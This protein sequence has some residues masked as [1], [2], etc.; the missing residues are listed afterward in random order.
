MF[1][2]FAL[3]RQKNNLGMS[4]LT[5]RKTWEIGNSISI[6]EVLSQK[7]GSG[8]TG[9]T[10]CSPDLDQYGVHEDDQYLGQ[11]R[12]LEP[13]IN[14]T[15]HN[16]V[17]AKPGQPLSSLPDAAD[18]QNE[19]ISW[20]LNIHDGRAAGSN[21]AASLTSLP[22]TATGGG[23]KAYV[24]A[25]RIVSAEGGGRLM[26]PNHQQQVRRLPTEGHSS[27]S[28]WFIELPEREDQQPQKATGKTSSAVSARP[29]TSSLITASN[30]L[31]SQSSRPP[32]DHSRLQPR[33]LNSKCPVGQL[34]GQPSVSSTADGSQSRPAPVMVWPVVSEAQGPVV[35]VARGV[36]L[37]E[38]VIIR[39]SEKGGA[40][41]SLLVAT[42]N[43]SRATDGRIS[44]GPSTAAGRSR[45]NKSSRSTTVL[46]PPVGSSSRSNKFEGRAS[47]HAAVRVSFN[48]LYES[49]WATGSEEEAALEGRLATDY[50]P[51]CC[52]INYHSSASCSSQSMVVGMRNDG[53][54][55]HCC[56]F[57]TNKI[58]KSSSSS[59]LT[60]SGVVM[61]NAGDDSA[62]CR[63]AGD[64]SVECRSCSSSSIH[65]SSA[66][67]QALRQAPAHNYHQKQNDNNT[68]AAKESDDQSSLINNRCEQ[69]GLASAS[70]AGPH[71]PTAGRSSNQ[72]VAG[73]WK[74][75]IASSCCQNKDAGDD[76]QTDSSGDQIALACA[77]QLLEVCARNLLRPLACHH[78]INHT[79][80]K[81]E[82][83]EAS[84]PSHHKS[85]M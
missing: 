82:P 1:T 60:A 81:C 33:L 23:V 58:A 30:K 22:K 26:P 63:N 74:T 12:T 25:E 73:G 28:C 24:S 78:I 29:I 85:H 43:N 9:T 48:M 13:R 38:A 76:E 35:P 64:D 32:E 36:V 11:K 8:C 37:A 31:S 17:E 84:L 16:V 4:L 50:V 77:Q 20:L 21:K 59:S 75:L 57:S 67:I 65:R 66:I 52:S 70:S 80:N 18:H 3:C 2:S 6:R 44:L 47:H 10:D 46:M 54:K 40:T 5:Q 51:Q 34:A 56:C 55:S 45:G 61:Q 62:E 53:Q 39:D 71:H 79:C 69:N 27:R 41:P 83:F 19:A 49:A 15:T 42:H 68:A 14:A 7:T 72:N